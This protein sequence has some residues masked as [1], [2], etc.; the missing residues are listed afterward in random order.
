MGDVLYR[1]QPSTP[2]KPFHGQVH[3]CDGRGHTLFFGIALLVNF[4][5]PIIYHLADYRA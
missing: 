4:T 5:A 1:F 2:L 3:F